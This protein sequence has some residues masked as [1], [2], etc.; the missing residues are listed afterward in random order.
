MAELA[1][2]AVWLLA[3]NTRPGVFFTL[4]PA[5][6]VYPP[7]SFLPSIPDCENKNFY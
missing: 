1:T 5:I 4:A 7:R 2:A 6:R 3:K